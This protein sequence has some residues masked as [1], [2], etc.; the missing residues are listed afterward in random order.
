MDRP[1]LMSSPMSKLHHDDDHE[2][3]VLD[4]TRGKDGVVFRLEL[5]SNLIV[6]EGSAAQ[7][8][9]DLNCRYSYLLY[10]F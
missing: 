6:V 2:C 8:N 4:N 3:H 1:S 5:A 10:S 7:Q 9:G